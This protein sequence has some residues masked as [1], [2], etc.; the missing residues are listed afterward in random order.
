[1]T[2]NKQ[3][4]AVEWLFA[5]LKNHLDMPSNQSIEILEQAKEME[6][7][8]MIKLIQ[9]V[10][11]EKELVDYSSVS[12]ETANYYYDKFNEEGGNK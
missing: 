1:M 5:E 7:E 11:S 3:Q 6:K 8:R 12:K 9:F 10:V 4:T 2:H